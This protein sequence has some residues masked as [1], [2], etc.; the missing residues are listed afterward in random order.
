MLVYSR[1]LHKIKCFQTELYTQDEQFSDVTQYRKRILSFFFTLSVCKSNKAGNQAQLR[2]C[3]FNDRH[4]WSE[5]LDQP[6]PDSFLWRQ[7]LSPRLSEKFNL[8]GVLMMSPWINGFWSGPN[9]TCLL[10]RQC[11]ISSSANSHSN[12]HALQALTYCLS[13]MQ[14]SIYDRFKINAGPSG[15]LR[16]LWYEFFHQ[17]S[18]L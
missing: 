7:R 18:V 12:G 8:P 1:L 10:Q 5:T 17:K 16:T 15:S 2:R 3:V 11:L 13:C 6:L 9:L 4:T 14:H